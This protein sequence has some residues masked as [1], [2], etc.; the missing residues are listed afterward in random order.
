MLLQSA[1]GDELQDA[2]ASVGADAFVFQVTRKSMMAD[3]YQVPLDKVALFTVGLQLTRAEACA[4]AGQ[5]QAAV[6]ATL[7]QHL[8]ETASAFR[9]VQVVRMQVD[10][11]SE[12]C[13]GGRRGRKL[14][15]PYSS[16]S[17][18]VDMMVVFTAE[19]KAVF[20]P[21]AFADKPGI[22]SVQA[23]P[24]NSRDISLDAN[25]NCEGSG[26]GL[27]RPLDFSEHSDEEEGSGNGVLI[28]GICSGVGALMLCSAGAIMHLRSRQ[29][30]PTACI[31]ADD[32]SSMRH[33]K[34]ELMES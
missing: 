31:E 13:G 30:T 24:R 11:G 28:A 23:D 17:A 26:C 15:A 21:E 34:A 16:A 18:E 9:S 19:G 12:Q 5:R 7:E 29:R 2:Q 22:T 8:A 10:M 4:A 6:R 1:G 32:L 3:V 27:M 25:F 20:N 14:L 33:L